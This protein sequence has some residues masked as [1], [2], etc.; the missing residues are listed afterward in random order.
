MPSGR[1]PTARQP[2][3]DGSFEWSGVDGVELVPAFA[4]GP[5][6][7]RLLELIQVLGDRLPG[8]RDLV[9]H[10]QAGA[11]LEERLVVP[12]GQLVQDQ[13]AGRVRDRLEDVTHRASIGKWWLACRRLGYIDE[14]GLVWGERVRP[15]RIC[16]RRSSCAPRSAAP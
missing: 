15:P 3:R 2:P 1:T 9:L 16:S 10:G 6:Q 5:H 4:P 8:Q 7:A 11:D 14:R 12:L 13:P